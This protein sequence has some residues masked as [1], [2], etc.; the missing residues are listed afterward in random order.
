MNRKKWVR[1]LL[2][3]TLTL[4]MIF[5]LLAAC[6]NKNEVEPGQERVLRI[7]VEYG[8]YGGDDTYFRQ[9]YT[10]VYEY[11]NKGVRIEIVPAIDASEQRYDNSTDGS[12][13]EPDRVE[14]Y[15]KMMTSANPVDIVVTDANQ[16]R[17]LVQDGML[18]QLDPLIQQDKVDTSDYVPTVIDGIKAMGNNNLYGLAPTFYSQALFY[19]KTMFQE[20]GVNPPTD[21][22]TWE[23]MF[24]LARRVSKG[25]GADRQYGFSFN[26]YRGTEPF[27]D[28]IHTYIPPLN[29]QLIDEKGEKMTVNSPKWETVFS[30]FSKLVNEKVIPGDNEDMDM[31]GSGEEYNPFSHDNFL[32]GHVAMVIGEYSYINS[33]LADAMKNAEKIKGFKKFDWDVVTVPSHPEAPGVAGGVSLSNIFSINQQAS[34]PDDAW[35]FIKFV[36]SEDWAKIRSRSSWEMVS[37]KKFI[38]AKDGSNFNI[39]AFYSVKPV[40]PTSADLSEVFNKMPNAWQVQEPGQTL[41]KDVVS[42]K[43]TSADAVKEW[44]TKGNQILQQLKK[45]PNGT[46]DPVQGNVYGN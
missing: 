36:N 31:A 32:S 5:P 42:G 15:K 20:A 33:D 18:K 13:K 41:F 24:N 27:W 10:D 12:R 34:N 29:L 23:D 35:D 9:Q 26:R 16:F 3:V 19:N 11:A 21:N 17:K 6:S 8:G 38:T 40:P 4:S 37:R 43:K 44:E 25:E 1:K 22:M 46:G 45:N 7:G 2:M 14:A 28:I 39:A 30:T